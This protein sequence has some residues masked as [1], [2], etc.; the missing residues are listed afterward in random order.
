MVLVILA[1]GQLAIPSAAQDNGIGV[2]PPKV[3][4]NRTLSIMLDE[5]N[6]RLR[7]IQ[8]VDQKALAGALGTQQGFQSQDASRSLTITGG[9]I[10][11]T[12][13]SVSTSAGATSTSETTTRAAQNP[14][15]PSL[16]ELLTPPAFNPKFGPAAADL[17]SDQVDLT[18]QIFNLR[19]LLERSLSDRLHNHATRLQA[20]LG[21][22]V[23]LDPSKEARD[24]AA[25]V[26]V[27]VTP[28][29]GADGPVSMVALMPQE[30]TYNSA[31][32]NQK[33]TAFGGSAV[34]RMITVGYTERRRGQIFY[35][36]R[37]TDTLSFERMPDGSHPQSVVFGWEFRPVL[38]RRSVSPGARQ[39]FAVI[40]L[41]ADD[42]AAASATFVNVSVRTYWRHYDR[43]TLTTKERGSFW[44][45]SQLPA[46]KERNFG[47]V[48]IPTTASIQND[49]S[50]VISDVSWVPTDDK[51]GVV[52][53][54]GR[55]F[56]TG[57][58]VT[59]GSTVHTGPT[60]GLLIKSEQS[61]QVLTTASAL[62]TGEGV[63][64]GRYGASIP[65][66]VPPATLPAPGIFLDTLTLYPLGAK[67]YEVRVHMGPD[68]LNVDDLA[69][70][71]SPPVVTV[72]DIPVG[73]F[74]L[75]PNP[76]GVDLVFDLPSSTLQTK[77]ALVRV[78]FPFAGSAWRGQIALYE[79]FGPQLARLGGDP[80]TTLLITK[81]GDAFNEKW[82]VELDHVYKV[83]DGT[84]SLTMPAPNMLSFVVDAAILKDYKALVVI[85]PTGVTNLLEI[86]STT[87]L[88][89]KPKLDAQTPPT[90]AQ[91]DSRGVAFTGSDLK[92]ITSVVFEDKNLP[93]SVEFD[94]KTKKMKIEVFLS[95]A[96][97]A[98]PG[99]VE[100][101]LKTSDGTILAA[102]VVVTPPTAPGQTKKGTSS[103]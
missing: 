47:S 75:A 40:S 80:K 93:F 50:P 10:P 7:D 65:L 83:N 26:E 16:P 69:K 49:L 91:D 15:I 99:T 59:L 54:N 74:Q 82:Q 46:P 67:F 35:L 60:D 97:T 98:K 101:L 61:L 14:S 24:S 27:T 63:L 13:E 57:T 45:H 33:S 36:F 4:D 48:P 20:V 86:P 56:F 5:L 90:I 42:G 103:G 32:L 2:G 88:A 95:R 9:G 72:N 68:S 70:K 30:K 53:V 17:L 66:V 52:I 89:A 38:G 23:T 39:M 58:T 11:A 71:L 94:E 77:D 81:K 55:N 34:A 8:F 28:A 18:Y 29:P 1:L 37:D 43:H 100:V 3:F 62:T 21:L 19:L 6:Q 85:S 73:P 31:A 76:K 64:T 78:V 25:T 84:G 51:T 102:P 87:P 96:V 79:P 41:P 92:A 12:S 22:N 44:R